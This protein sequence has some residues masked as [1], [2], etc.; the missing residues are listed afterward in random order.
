MLIYLC[1]SSH[2][3]GHAARQ[4]A[5]LS[6]LYRIHSDWRYVVS[7]VVDLR[8]LEIAF[9]DVPI[10]HR[11]VRWDV[12]MVQNNALEVD[13]KSTLNALNQ[14]YIELPGQIAKEASWIRHQDPEFLILADIPPSAV[15]LAKCLD[16]SVIWM[17]N[18]GWDEIYAPLGDSFKR[19][20]DIARKQYS[21]GNLLLKFPFYMEMDWGVK[22]M[23]VGLVTARPKEL[24]D[25]IL[26]RIKDFNGQ[27]ISVGFGG[28]GFELGFDLFEKWPN[29]LFFVMKSSN[30]N[31]W[32]SG[33]LPENICVLPNEVRLIDLLPYCDRQIGKP[34]FS[35]FCESMSQGVGLHVVQ[36]NDFAEADVLLNGL[37]NYGLH[38]IIDINSLLRGDWQLERPLNLPLKKSLPVNGAY[39]AA[40]SIE[41]YISK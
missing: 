6:E 34:G 12:G 35:S 24:P 9:R 22:S 30:T 28:F 31:R 16:S 14:L 10:E 37:R 27:I 19:H 36:R 7:S 15:E 11:R 21:K 13:R 8:F 40:K 17:G 3:F 38:R 26:S 18:F 41:D 20:S 4:S 1:L 2:G 33:L 39:Y 23:Q 29:H 5:V 32:T 25:N